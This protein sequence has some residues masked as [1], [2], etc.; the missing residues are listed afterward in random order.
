MKTAIYIMLMLMMASCV[1]AAEYKCFPQLTGVYS[2]NCMRNFDNVTNAGINPEVELEVGTYSNNLVRVQVKDDSSF[3]V[4]AY[5]GYTQSMIPVYGYQTKLEGNIKTHL[6]Y[7]PAKVS[8]YAPLVSAGKGQ[9]DFKVVPKYSTSVDV[10]E[11]EVISGFM[12][13]KSPYFLVLN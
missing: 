9:I 4:Y 5:S 6:F 10:R 11:I 12:Q 13:Q 1:F 3:L 7:L 8:Q 2:T